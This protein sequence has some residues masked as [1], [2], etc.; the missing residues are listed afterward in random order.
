MFA[1][2]I[3]SG[4]QRRQMRQLAVAQLRR[5]ARAAAPSRCR[6]SRST[7]GSRPPAAHVEAERAQQRLDAAAQLLAVLQRARRMEGELPRVAPAQAAAAARH[8]ASGSSSHRSFVSS[9]MRARLAPRRPDRA[10]ARGRIPSPSRR[11]R[12]R[13]SRSP[14][15]SP[16]STQRPPRVDVAPHVGERRRRG[17]S[18]AARIA[19]QQPAPSATTRWMP[20]A[21]STRA[22]ALLMFGAIA[23]CTQPSQHQHLARMLARRPACAR[24]PALRRHLV[25][26]A[27]AAA[28]AANAWP[29]FSAGAEQR[30]GQALLAAASAARARPAGRCDLAHRRRSRPMSTS[31]PY[32]TPDG[33]VVSQVRQVRQR[34]RCSCVFA[35]DRRAFEHL[36]HQVDA[37]ARAVEL[38]AEQLVGRAGRGAEAAVHALAQDRLG[39][40]AFGRVLDEV[41][42]IGLHRAS[43]SVPGT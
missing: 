32:C 18:G 42:E 10:R 15:R 40:A 2:T 23:G 33:Q 21:S 30:R 39:F 34:S 36:L 4:S 6:P 8:A 22:V 26:A 29:S 16:R 14:R 35:R 9:P 12:T 3:A 25:R 20:Q 5:P 28:A 11:S 17:R 13:S 37:P 43:K 38:V 1:D 19:P 41:G 7:G 27:P 31:R 24:A